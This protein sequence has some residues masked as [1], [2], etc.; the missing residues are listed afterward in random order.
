MLHIDW[1]P[2]PPASREEE[3][4]YFPR[5]TSR[6]TIGF[7]ELCRLAARNS[8][9]NRGEL[10]AVFC[11]VLQELSHQLAEGKIVQIPELGDFRLS[12]QANGRI[13]GKKRGDKHSAK[14]KG[15]NFSPSA[16][17]IQSLGDL[18]FQWSPSIVHQAPCDLPSMKSRLDE[19]FLS[20]PAISRSQFEELFGL[21][22]ST[23]NIRLACLVADGYLCKA[24]TGK[25]TRY[26]KP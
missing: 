8:R 4:T 2:I 13:T 22:R 20:N 6:G 14:L 1:Q 15:V 11:E 23:S 26:V 18:Q 7:E 17:F 24:G 3:T 12:V 16:D 5:L 21:P 9:Y 25:D 19:Y 10:A